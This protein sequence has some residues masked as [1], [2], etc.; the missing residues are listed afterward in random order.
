ML[1]HHP[2]LTRPTQVSLALVGILLGIGGCTEEAPGPQA[3]PPTEVTAVT[4][5][6][7]DIPAT[8]DFVGKT[9]STRKVEIRAR[10]QGFLD[11][12]SYEEGEIVKAG[13]TLFLM[14][15]KPFEAKLKVAKAALGQQEARLRTARANLNRVRPLA[16]ENAV[17]QK[18][19]DDAIGQEQA[20]AAAVEAARAEVIGADLDLGYTTIGSPVEGLSSYAVVT[21]GTYVDFSN[22]LLT[23]VSVLSP[24]RVSFSVSENQILKVRD[25][26]ALGHLRS[27]ERA[28]YEV[29]IGLADGS[30]FPEKGRITFAD[31]EFSETTGTYLLRAEVPN[32]QTVLRPGQFV[33]VKLSGAVRPKAI[34]VPKRAVLQTAQGNMVFLVAKDGKAEPRPV[35]LGDWFGEDWIVTEG[36]RAGEQVAVDGAIKLRP[37]ASVKVVEAAGAAP[38]KDAPVATA[39]P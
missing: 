29:E 16:A 20:A 34:L 7:K 11:K 15:R 1:I 14:D 17:S 10:V 28:D 22:S 27:P 8:Y 24:I 9:E 39:K 2:F 21:E 3:T 13:Q 30:V 33:Q 37:G 23:N 26:A 31:A 36:L 5:T 12:R 38:K 4:V 18:D 25:E 6:P 35:M 19:L 32:Q